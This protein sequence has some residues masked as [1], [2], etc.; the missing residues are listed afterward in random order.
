[1]FVRSVF[2]SGE[3]AGGAICGFWRASL[4][5][6]IFPGVTLDEARAYCCVITSRRLGFLNT[7]CV[8]GVGGGDNGRR[9]GLRNTIV[10]DFFIDN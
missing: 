4:L 9:G 5:V 1:M 10:V 2:N 8:L 7:E 3:R 6:I